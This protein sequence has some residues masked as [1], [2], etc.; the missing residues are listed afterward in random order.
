MTIIIFLLSYILFTGAGGCETLPALG[1]ALLVSVINILASK[2]V[3]WYD[4]Q[5]ELAKKWDDIANGR[6]RK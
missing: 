4:K 2:F 6:Y 5:K 1:L 3:E